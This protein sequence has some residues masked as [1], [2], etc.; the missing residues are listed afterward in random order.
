MTA[1]PN[2][3]AGGQRPLRGSPG[4]FTLLEIILALTI[5]AGAV[6]VLGEVSRFGMRCAERARDMTHA[7]LLCEGKLA[8]IVAGIAPA[9]AVDGAAFESADDAEPSEWLYSV[10]LNTTDT[11]GLIEV[12]VTVTKDR[13]AE[14][15]PA[16]VSLVRWMVDPG[17]ELS[18]E[19][20]AAEAGSESSEAGAEL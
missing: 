13:P 12:R 15:R 20:T 18:E 7:Q 16:E 4:G 14:M 17:I 3:A 11:E 10:E 2:Q 6:A 19:T 5:L 8:E 9:E 1:A